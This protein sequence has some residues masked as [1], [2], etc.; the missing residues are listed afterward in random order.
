M[1]ATR[2]AFS[3]AVGACAS[4]EQGNGVGLG[5]GET[6]AGW[7][8]A[9]AGARGGLARWV[10][11]ARG[12]GAGGSLLQ[13]GPTSAVGREAERRPDKKNEEFFFF[14]FSNIQN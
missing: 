6:R 5:R 13:A 11:E 9:W 1:V 4:G 2:R 3:A 8:D 12:V 7:R 10:G 14:Y